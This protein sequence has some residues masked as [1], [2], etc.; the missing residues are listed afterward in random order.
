MPITQP[1]MP[2][3]HTIKRVLLR[4]LIFVHSAAFALGCA[5]MFPSKVATGVARLTVKN[6]GTITQ[7]V[8]ADTTCGFAS[9]DVKAQV[10]YKGN[11]GENGQALWQVTRCRI[12]LNQSPVSSDCSGNQTLA[13]GVLIVTA[14]Q[15]ISGRLTGDA[16]TPAIPENAHGAVIR[17][18]HV[19]FENFKVFSEGDPNI[20]TMK[21]GAISATVAPKLAQDMAEGVCQVI[22]PIV[23]FEDIQY[24][25]S[26]VLVETE[27]DSFSVFVD[28][29]KIWAQNGTSGAH[30]NAIGGTVSVW[31]KT[32]EVPNDDA[33]LN[34]DYD[35]LSFQRELEC[36][37]SIQLPISHACSIN[38]MLGLGAARL[39]MQTLAGLLTAVFDDSACGFASQAAKDNALTQGVIGDA[40][41]SATMQVTNCELNFPEPVVISTNCQG[42]ATTIQGRAVITGTQTLLGILSG[43]PDEPIVPTSW[44]PTIL[45]LNANLDGL[46]VKNSNSEQFMVVKSGLLSGQVVPRTAID[47]SLGA[48]TRVT[49]VARISDVHWNNSKVTLHNEG[50]AFDLQL[51]AANLRGVNG[52]DGHAINQ[53]SGSINVDGNHVDL[54]V[55]S[56]DPNYDPVAFDDAYLCDENLMSAFT[57]DDC[58][59]NDVIAISTARL[60]I[61]TFGG[62]VMSAEHDDNCGFS[63]TMNLVPDSIE[64]TD[65]EDE[66]AVSWEI[67]DCEIGSEESQFIQADCFGNETYIEGFAQIDALKE[68]TGVLV[69]DF[70][71]L[72]PS[73]PEASKF[74]IDSAYLQN[75]S[76][77]I[78]DAQTGEV[79]PYLIIQEAL[80]SG[81]GYPVTGESLSHAGAY[82]IATPLLG[83]EDVAISPTNAVLVAGK[84]RFNVEIQGAQLAGF[85]GAYGSQENELT[86][87]ITIGGKSY[88][89]PTVHDQRGLHPEYDPNK[90]KEGYAC[91]DDLAGVLPSY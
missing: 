65:V 2:E 69:L 59:M 43:D 89:L 18:E 11:V 67:S 25:A 76:I 32:R 10:T 3:Y 15:E 21:S 53:L 30:E 91:Y 55:Q 62:I 77:K 72:E 58:N 63:E 47:T 7:I 36:I 83:F 41:A 70:P 12:E 50:L 56:L 71:P 87:H 61:R 79:G 28:E 14:Q 68:A 78:A 88:A 31:G 75:F 39:T 4:T 57:N 24:Q 52:A 35:P 42:V 13:S 73:H 38:T 90:F 48:C 54:G 33:G 84:K 6:I 27:D 51:D 19:E 37:D 49:P 44:E 23:S 45:S 40:G 17:L 29:S 80:L 26:E 85:N 60:M 9:P 20:L 1:Y 66:V 16:Q 22:T 8:S 86:G 46:V 74:T 64:Q 81:V 5:Q 82:Y 34:P